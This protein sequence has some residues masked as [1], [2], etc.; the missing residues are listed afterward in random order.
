MGGYWKLAPTNA[1]AV[2]VVL[3]RAGWEDSGP[4]FISR[5]D[6]LLMLLQCLKVGA[7]NHAYAIH[8]PF[9][10]ASVRKSMTDL[11]MLFSER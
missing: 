3:T 4:G 6:V 9:F 11:M 7:V 10:P 8:K 1:R 2:R 5:E